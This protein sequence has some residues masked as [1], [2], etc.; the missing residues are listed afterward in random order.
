VGESK[1]LSKELADTLRFAAR[2]VK[3]EQLKLKTH[4]YLGMMLVLV[5][6]K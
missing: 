1:R 5:S 3:Q 4:S 6:E 2:P